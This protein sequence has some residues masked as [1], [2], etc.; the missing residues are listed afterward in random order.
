LNDP[1]SKHVNL[2]RL[3]AYEQVRMLLSQP[4]NR[5]AWS[6][7]CLQPA[8]SISNY[9]SQQTRRVG[10]F[11]TLVAKYL[12]A[13]TPD[14]QDADTLDGLALNLAAMAQIFTESKRTELSAEWISEQL[15]NIRR[16]T[17][18]DNPND[19]SEE[20]SDSLEA[21]SEAGDNTSSHDKPGTGDDIIDATDPINTCD[22]AIT[23]SNANS[24]TGIDDKGS[25]NSQSSNPVK[26][27]WRV[28]SQQRG[29]QY[30]K[31]P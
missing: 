19:A 24:T 1:N 14:Q 17:V 15:V 21:Q 22:R 27:I 30:D 3:V 18:E 29:E 13:L 26:H 23:D 11:F 4:F 7:P 8:A 16:N 12:L 31:R 28:R 2:Q 10:H 9:H 25:D 6:Y 5:F 20:D